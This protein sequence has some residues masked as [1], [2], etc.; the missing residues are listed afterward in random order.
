MNKHLKISPKGVALIKEFEGLKLNSYRDA[1]GIWTIGYGHTAT[2]K[3]NQKIT[4]AQ[5]D[6]LLAQDIAKFETLTHTHVKVPLT[7]GQYDAFVSLLFNVGP[8][9]SSKSGII[10][11]ANGQPST[12]LRRL[13]AKDYLGAALAF[14]DWKMAGGKVLAGLVRRREAEYKLFMG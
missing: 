7:Q 10:R 2:A 4:E 3:P 6:A 1:V 8:G 13:N 9:N 14:K 12:L 5:A 11:L